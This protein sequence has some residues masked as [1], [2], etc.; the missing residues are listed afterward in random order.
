MRWKAL[1]RDL[2]PRDRLAANARVEPGDLILPA[3]EAG[4]DGRPRSATI[5]R[6][7]GLEL[8]VLRLRDRYVRAASQ[9]LR[10][11]VAQETGLH[12]REVAADEEVELGAGPGKAAVDATQRPAAREFVRQETDVATESQAYAVRFENLEAG[13]LTHD[14]DGTADTLQ[15]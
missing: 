15:Q 12:K 5:H 6:R 4:L 10:G 9:R 7:Q 14:R 8:P 2:R 3:L 13:R 1:A 11:N